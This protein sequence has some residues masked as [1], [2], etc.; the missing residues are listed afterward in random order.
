M[1][2]ANFVTFYVLF[3]YYFMCVNMRRRS[4]S[5]FVDCLLTGPLLTEQF[6]FNNASE[7]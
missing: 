6:D 4:I 7:A 2:S 3:K 1:G 5:I